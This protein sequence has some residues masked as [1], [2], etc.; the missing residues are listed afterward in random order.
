VELIYNYSQLSES[1]IISA[2][3]DFSI[4]L[5]TESIYSSKTKD[6]F[7]EVIKSYYNTCYRSAVVSGWAS[8][9]S[10]F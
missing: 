7:N 1:L 4:D 3:R 9:F 8:L 2:K 6:Y 5:Q 10:G